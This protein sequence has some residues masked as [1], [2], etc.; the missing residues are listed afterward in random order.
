MPQPPRSSASAQR[1]STSRSSSV[2]SRSAASAAASACSPLD[3]H[4]GRQVLDLLAQ[5]RVDP[6]LEQVAR[7]LGGDGRQ[8]PGGQVAHRRALR[9]AAQ[10]GRL[11]ER[12]VDPRRRLPNPLQPLEL[13]PPP[14]G[15]AQPAGQQDGRGQGG[16][17]PPG[18]PLGRRLGLGLLRAGALGGAG[19]LGLAQPLLHAG[20]VGGQ[21]L[22]DD[23]R[24]GRPVLRARRPGSRGPGRA[25]RRRPRT[26]RSR[27]SA[28]AVSPRLA[29][30]RT[31]RIDCR[32]RTPA[33]R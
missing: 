31:S 19:Q 22:G 25:A 18:P 6:R 30:P 26:P 13:D 23:A 17:Q 29:R 14:A 11:A 24:V 21:P 5:R 16:G 1:M 3:R 28:S 7:L 9:Q 27:A 4:L 15:A 2:R 32:R 33:R 8:L 20:Q 12:E 10:P